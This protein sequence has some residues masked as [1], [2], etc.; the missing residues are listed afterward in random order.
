VR[1]VF[2]PRFRRLAGGIIFMAVQALAAKARRR[3]ANQRIFYTGHSYGFCFFVR[4]FSQ[5]MSFLASLRLGGEQ[6]FIFE[7]MNS[8]K[9]FHPLWKGQ[10]KPTTAADIAQIID[11]SLLNPALTDQDLLDGIALAKSHKVASVCIKPYF[12]TKAVELLE[13]SGVSVGSVVGFPHG[14]SRTAVKIMEAHQ[15]I[16]SG[17]TELDMVVNIGKVLSGDWLYVETDIRAVVNVCKTNQSIS[18]VIFENGYLADSQKV[19][20]CQIC[21]KLGAD[22]V[23]TSTGFGPAGATPE[24]VQLMRSNVSGVGVKAAGGI[25]DLNRFLEMVELGATRVGT[26]A[27]AKIMEEAAKKFK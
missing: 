27:T 22:F 9:P 24:D 11:H 1:K 8:R 19:R 5:N 14:S 18:K 23:K 12:V 15:A 20:L 25:E 13:F 7:P 4:F 10:M 3:K 26:S 2:T 17:A 21:E 6:L 16:Q